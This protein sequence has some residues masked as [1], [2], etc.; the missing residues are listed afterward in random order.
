MEVQYGIVVH[1]GTTDLNASVIQ[2]VFVSIEDALHALDYLPEH[3]PHEG[4]IFQE[5]I[6][7]ATACNVRYFHPLWGV[8][9][10]N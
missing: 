7:E 1:E 8:Q 10:A 2:D 5:N 3:V 4:F 9:R 6:V